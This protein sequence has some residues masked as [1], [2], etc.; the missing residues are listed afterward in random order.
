MSD[1]R[2]GRDRRSG[3]GCWYKITITECAICGGG[4]EHRER[5]EP[6]APPKEARYEF[7]QTACVDHFL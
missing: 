4:D 1:S 6:P 7:I 2:Q 5:R 3:K